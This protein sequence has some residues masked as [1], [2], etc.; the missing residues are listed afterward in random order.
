MKF[1]FCAC[2]ACTWKGNKPHR[3]GQCPVCGNALKIQIRARRYSP[4][5]ASK[6]VLSGLSTDQKPKPP[7]PDLSILKDYRISEHE[8]RGLL[9]TGETIR[10]RMIESVSRL[11]LSDKP[12]KW[13]A[14]RFRSDE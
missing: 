3:D 6:L 7:L 5:L 10:N 14:L 1:Y 11:T 9:K 4:D 12:L 2:V 8:L 13:M